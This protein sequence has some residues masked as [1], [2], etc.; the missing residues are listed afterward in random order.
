MVK[1]TV[2][3]RAMFTATLGEV[4]GPPFLSV[5][6]IFTSVGVLAAVEDSARGV[7]ASHDTLMHLFERVHFS[8]Q[9]L[10]TYIGIPLIH[11]FTD[12]LG[13]IMSQLLFILAVSTKAIT[14]GRT[15]QKFSED[16]G[17]KVG[18]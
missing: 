11:E 12:Q 18:G 5:K 6:T 16:A 13:R 9:R 17:R 8:L 2:H 1:T 10:N 3:V 15:N 4:F 7:A 14:N